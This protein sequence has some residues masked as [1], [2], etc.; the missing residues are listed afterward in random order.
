ML[1]EESRMAEVRVTRRYAASPER[2][3]E[4]WLDPNIASRFLFAT[5]TGD[6]IVRDIDARVGGRFELT[7]RRADMGDVRHVGEYLAIEPPSRLA[8]T[9]S[10]PQFDPAV[11]R[12]DVE[13][14]AVEGGCE[15]TLT[16]SDVPEAWAERDRAGW[17][18]ILASLERCVG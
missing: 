2:V 18:M 9:F 11:T 6:M 12:V 3:F 14:R 8:F 13:M 5:P 1:W 15:L 7:E 10:V 17:T 16:H 4:A